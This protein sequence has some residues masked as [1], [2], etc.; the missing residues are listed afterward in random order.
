[1]VSARRLWCRCG[2][3]VCSE[4]SS[5][6]RALGSL[7]LSSGF[8]VS[9]DQAGF[10]LRDI[11]VVGGSIYVSLEEIRVWVVCFR[12]GWS[13]ELRGPPL[14]VLNLQYNRNNAT[15]IK[16]RLEPF[17]KGE[18]R[19]YPQ[20]ESHPLESIL[21]KIPPVGSDS[22]PLATTTSTIALQIMLQIELPPWHSMVKATLFL[23]AQLSS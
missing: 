8:A 5:R 22:S 15:T 17:H 1:M 19:S 6:E 9:W 11:S 4:S 3:W 21:P 7:V 2:R 18:V 12:L 14:G 23:T 13:L 10:L 16:N 20:T